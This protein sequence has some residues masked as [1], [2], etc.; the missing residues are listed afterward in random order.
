LTDDQPD[1]LNLVVR[2]DSTF[3]MTFDGIPRALIPTLLRQVADQLEVGACI[4][5]D[6]NGNII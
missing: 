1:L 3:D 4:D 2:H 6:E 5:T